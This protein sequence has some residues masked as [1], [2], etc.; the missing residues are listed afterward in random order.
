M[1]TM[2]ARGMVTI[3]H[4]APEIGQGTYNLFSIVAAQTLDIPQDQ[5]RV[6]TPDTAVS[7]PF[8][9]VSAQRTTMQMGNAVHNACRKLKEELLS[10]A[11]QAKGGKPEEWQLIQGR[12]CW[13]ETS[14]SIS[15]IIRL[16]GGGMVLKA[17]G[18]HSSPPIAKD[19]AF[20]GLDHWGPGGGAGDLGARRGTG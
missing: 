12:L 2:D 4:N 13:G 15:E 11:A 19:S 9:G 16:G 18:Y 17:V 10:L 6:R 20:A 7:L 3:Q 14:F 8:G 5:I 1:A